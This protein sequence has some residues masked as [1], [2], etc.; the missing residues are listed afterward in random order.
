[1]RILSN[2]GPFIITSI[3]WIEDE[4]PRSQSKLTLLWGAMVKLCAGHYPKLYSYQNSLPRMPVPNLSETCKGLLRSVK[5]IL[6]EDEYK[7]MEALAKVSVQF[8]CGQ[9]LIWTVQLYLL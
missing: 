4:T 5:P 9:C 7:K 6:K 1:M 3:I 8:L 2:L